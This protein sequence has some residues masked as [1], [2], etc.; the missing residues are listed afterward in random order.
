[1]VQVNCSW[2][3][4]AIIARLEVSECRDEK[5]ILESRC[6]GVKPEFKILQVFSG[7]KHLSESGLREFSKKGPDDILVSLED[8]LMFR[9]LTDNEDEAGE[10]KITS[11][12]TEAYGRSFGKLD[13]SIES[14]KIRKGYASA[15]EIEEG[16][17][18]R[19]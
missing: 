10:D 2:L 11:L 4:E 17:E 6:Y 9:Y 12:V 14:W 13:E 1:V 3:L 18:R 15:N 5:Q 7:D 19:C 16:F 8:Q